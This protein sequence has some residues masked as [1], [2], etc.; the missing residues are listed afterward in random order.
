MTLKA[1]VYDH[2]W[3]GADIVFAASKEKAYAVLQA[4]YIPL[5][6]DLVVNHQPLNKHNPWV[7]RLEAWTSD[8]NMRGF[9]EHPITESYTITTEGDG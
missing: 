2:G 8:R 7:A 6:H 9:V 1:Y 4:K 5:Y 3:N